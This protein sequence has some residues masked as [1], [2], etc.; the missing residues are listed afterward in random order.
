MVED[1]YRRNYWDVFFCDILPYE[2]AEEL[3]EIAVNTGVQKAAS[4]LQSA[5]NILNKNQKLYDNIKVDGLLG[6][7]TLAT[8]KTSLTKVPHRLIYNVLNI[9]QGA[10]YVELMQKK[11]VYEKYIGWF[12]RI[13][14]MR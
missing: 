3:F 14:I 8:F 6:P 10:F 1:F 13:E 4:I 2:I 12:N 5:L 9:L 7:V 11:E